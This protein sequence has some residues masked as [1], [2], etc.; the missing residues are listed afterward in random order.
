MAD[1]DKLFKIETNAFDFIFKRQFV[2]RDEK[3][4][5]YLIAF[6][7]KKLHKSEFNYPIYNKELI[8][9]VELF[10]EQKPYLNKIKYQIKI[11]VNYK[12]LIYFIISKKLNQRQ[13]Q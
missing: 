9:I 11:Y 8:T 7:S 4:R 13:I 3:E 2:Q 6:F 12:N 1:L 5:L 10:K